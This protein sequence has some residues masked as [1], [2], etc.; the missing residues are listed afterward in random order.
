IPALH[1][2]L[3][4]LLQTDLPPLPKL[5]WASNAIMATAPT[6]R[7]RALNTRLMTRDWIGL[8]WQLKIVP[9]RLSQYV[10]T[11]SHPTLI[12]MDGSNRRMDSITLH[13]SSRMAG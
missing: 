2:L 1:Q 4:L 5:S 13:C 12:S 9:D 6:G 8:N 10:P 11:T 3:V 7:A